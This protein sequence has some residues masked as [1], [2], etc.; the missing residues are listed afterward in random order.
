MKKVSFFAFAL[1][2]VGAIACNNPSSSEEATTDT[3]EV[4]E[5]AIEEEMEVEEVM[6]EVADSTAEVMDTVMEAAGDAME[7]MHDHADGEDHADHSEM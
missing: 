1:I 5:E 3:M 6:T 4:V 2:F 7:E